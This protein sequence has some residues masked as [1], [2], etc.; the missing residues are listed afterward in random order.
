MPLMKATTCRWNRLTHCS[1]MVREQK[2]SDNMW[3]CRTVSYFDLYSSAE[4]V[5]APQSAPPSPCPTAYPA[6]MP[7]LLVTPT[8]AHLQCTGWN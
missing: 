2:S 5:P 7:T 6:T 1:N 4:S 8:P 3:S